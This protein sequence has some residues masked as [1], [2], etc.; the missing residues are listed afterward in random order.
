AGWGA[1]FCFSVLGHALALPL[2]PAQGRGN[3]ANLLPPRRA[4]LILAMLAQER[5][6]RPRCGPGVVLS[7][8]DV[9]WI[10]PW[11]HPTGVASAWKRRS[12]TS[13]CTARR[14]RR[15]DTAKS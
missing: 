15:C 5:A 1:H 10:R 12:S 6:C 13:P 14:T 8:G 3:G 11:S 4:S 9:L 7:R 2:V